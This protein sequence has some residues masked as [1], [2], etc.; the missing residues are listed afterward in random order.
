M[1]NRIFSALA[2]VRRRPI[3]ERR[4]LGAAI[5]IGVSFVI[6][7]LWFTSLRS[8]LTLAPVAAPPQGNGYAGDD[9]PKIED[10]AGLISPWQSLKEGL[11]ETVA[12]AKRILAGAGEPDSEGKTSAPDEYVDLLAPLPLTAA[13]TPAAETTPVPK[14]ETKPTPEANPVRT[15]ASDRSQQRSNGVKKEK[16]ANRPAGK[17]AASPSPAP[18]APKLAEEIAGYLPSTASAL[19]ETSKLVRPPADD[20]AGQTPSAKSGF[21][22]EVANII[23]YN[24]REMKR[25]ASD[26]YKYFTE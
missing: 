3:V 19:G 23:G 22:R 24:L 10:V 9:A 7:A 16:T 13:A 11:T 12:G 26:L 1:L 20:K 21:P 18:Q 25:A 14:T 8:T 5:Y 2:E 17:A 6:L 15:G 4:V